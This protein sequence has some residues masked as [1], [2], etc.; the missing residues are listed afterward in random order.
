[1]SAADMKEAMT[2]TN[3]TTVDLSILKQVLTPRMGVWNYTEFEEVLPFGGSLLVRGYKCSE[4]GFFRRKRHGMSK[5]C[6]DCG[7]RMKEDTK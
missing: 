5:F 4:C 1:M 6:E 7:A 3:Q 2:M